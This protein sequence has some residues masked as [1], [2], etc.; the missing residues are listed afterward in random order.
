MGTLHLLQ[1]Q[2]ACLG[3]QGFW[4]HLVWVPGWLTQRRL[5]KN[6]ECNMTPCETGT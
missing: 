6:K 2:P 1:G 5:Y 3:F 4:K